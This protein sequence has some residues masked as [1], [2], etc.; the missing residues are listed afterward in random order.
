MKK[1]I[2]Q[3]T[4]IKLAILLTAMI[5]I[6]SSCSTPRYGCPVNASHGFGPGRMR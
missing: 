3:I 2:L 1:L 4:A 5:V 6:A